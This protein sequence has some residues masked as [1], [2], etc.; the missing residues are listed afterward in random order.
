MKNWASVYWVHTRNTNML[1]RILRSMK[2]QGYFFLGLVKKKKETWLESQ[3]LVNNLCWAQGISLWYQMVQQL[4]FLVFR[5]PS[6]TIFVDHWWN[7]FQ[8]DR[9]CSW[10]AIKKNVAE[11]PAFLDIYGLFFMY[12]WLRSLCR[13]N[14]SEDVTGSR[15][16][17]VSFS[18]LKF[19]HERITTTIE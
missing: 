4:F 9:E 12:V 18:R 2:I 3:N 16:V 1:K 13:C 8:I 5:G 15:K 17:D 14:H 7:V 6:C 11:W 19:K 10:I